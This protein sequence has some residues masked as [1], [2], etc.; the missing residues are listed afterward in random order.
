MVVER[1]C[2]YTFWHPITKEFQLDKFS[3]EHA[4]VDDFFKSQ[5]Q[6]GTRCWWWLIYRWLLAICF[7]L[8]VLGSLVQHFNEGKWFIYLTDWGF[9]LCMYTSLF[10]AILVS[11]YHCNP[12]KFETGSFILKFYWASH[13]STLV[14]ATMITFVYWLFIYPNDNA[15]PTALYNLWAHAFNSVLMLMDHMLVAFPTRILHFIYPFIAGVLYGLFSVIYYFAGG[16]DPGGN[17]YIYE[18][19]DWSQPG[20]ALATVFGCILLVCVFCLLLFG[21]YKLRIF[22]YRKTNKSVLTFNT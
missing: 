20:W 19:L 16:L 7:F 3:L 11:V 15:S 13:W 5:W 17:Q 18:I 10:G 4:P 1:G 6:K 21:L 2:C 8:G 9:F 22:I 12:Q 14:L